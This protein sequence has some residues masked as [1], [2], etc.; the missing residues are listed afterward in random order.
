MKDTRKKL[1]SVGKHAV[2]FGQLSVYLEWCCSEDGTVV[3]E[4]PKGHPGTQNW[5]QEPGGGG[6]GA[7]SWL[8]D[9]GI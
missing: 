1:S 7:G 5:A 6:G 4:V 9:E 2:F 3:G 8:A